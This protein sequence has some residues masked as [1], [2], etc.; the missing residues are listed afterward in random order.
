MHECDISMKLEIKSQQESIAYYDDE[1]F[2]KK[3]ASRAQK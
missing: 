3:K 1:D 2:V